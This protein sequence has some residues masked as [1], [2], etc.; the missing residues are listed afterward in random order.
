MEVTMLDLT[1][2]RPFKFHQDVERDIRELIIDEF[3]KLVEEYGGQY[4][5]ERNHRHNGYVFSNL[6][7]LKDFENAFR[8]SDI[9]P[10]T[11]YFYD[12]TTEM[13]DFEHLK[14]K[15]GI[16]PSHLLTVL[17]NSWSGWNEKG[18][19]SNW[20]VIAAMYNLGY[21]DL[22][23]QLLPYPFL[24]ENEE[25]EKAYYRL[26][27]RHDNEVKHY[28][29]LAAY[30]WM[31]NQGDTEPFMEKN[32]LFSEIL[33]LHIQ[34]DNISPDVIL[35]HL[36]DGEP[37]GVIRDSYS[38]LMYFVR[39]TDKLLNLEHKSFFNSRYPLLEAFSRPRNSWI[40]MPDS[41]EFQEIAVMA[42]NLWTSEIRRDKRESFKVGLNKQLVTWK[43]F[44]INHHSNDTLLGATDIG[45]ILYWR[46]PTDHEKGQIREL[47]KSGLIAKTTDTSVFRSRSTQ[48]L[49]KKSDVIEYIN[50]HRKEEIERNKKAFY[51]KIKES[52]SD[53]LI[54][55]PDK[56][57]ELVTLPSKEP[58]KYY[59]DYCGEETIASLNLTDTFNLAF[60]KEGYIQG[61]DLN[62]SLTTTIPLQEIYGPVVFGH[63][64]AKPLSEKDIEMVIK[65]NE[66]F[67]RDDLIDKRFPIR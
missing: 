45:R 24:A 23:V 18:T 41:L 67:R 32:Y 47:F 16:V 65:M 29:K 4:C 7:N 9:Y 62:I 60:N 30:Q 33:K 48:Y 31:C 54:L 63:S 64:N 8:H 56:K 58:F 1:I 35:Y 37:F 28:L 34:V 2:I 57:M 11:K 42:S 40:N 49:A 43:S 55:Y 17:L 38:M 12:K 27:D 44:D 19:P 61:L 15:Q 3:K 51:Q 22:D 14:N 59:F 52:T 25:C 6:N 10:M 26:S 13:K 39:P 5:E 66:Q 36:A 21:F 20:Y 53:V 50:S 46:E